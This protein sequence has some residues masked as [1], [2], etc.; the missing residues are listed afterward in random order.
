LSREAKAKAPLG[1]NN[2]AIATSLTSS[3]LLNSAT[4]ALSC[5]GKAKAP[6][7][8]NSEATTAS[9]KSRSPLGYATLT[10]S[11]RV[12]TL[13]AQIASPCEANLHGKAILASPTS[14]RR[15]SKVKP[16][17]F[18][19]KKANFQPLRVSVLDHLGPANTYMRENLSSKRK[20]HSEE[21]VHVSPSQCRQVGYQ[22]VIVHFVL[23]CLGYSPLRLLQIS[24]IF[25]TD[26][27]SNHLRDLSLKRRKRQ[28][29]HTSQ[30]P[31]LI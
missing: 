4:K 19:P 1:D 24:N 13:K 14:I 29:F 25:L 26:Y 31:L 15:A 16:K 3:A 7:G 27:Q 30:L 12:T 11:S 18:Q 20:L 17:A 9:L 5:E 6:I 23:C 21:S 10:S 8:A 22:L 28:R 2:E